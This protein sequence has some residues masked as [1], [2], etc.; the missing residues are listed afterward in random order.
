[1][2]SFNPD[3]TIKLEKKEIRTEDLKNSQELN[4]FELKILK[5]RDEIIHLKNIIIPE[6]K[7]FI[8]KG[9]TQEEQTRRED[10]IRFAEARLEELTKEKQ[11]LLDSKYAVGNDEDRILSLEEATT[12]DAN[13]HSEEE[14][15]KVRAKYA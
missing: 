14:A 12:I 4:E 13:N 5:I 2:T 1:M 7:K 15:N 3:Q 8:G 6:L 10:G 11:S 9:G